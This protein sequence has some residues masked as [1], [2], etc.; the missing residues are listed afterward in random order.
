MGFNFTPINYTKIRG[1]KTEDL[2]LTFTHDLVSADGVYGHSENE[3]DSIDLLMNMDI[4]ATIFAFYFTYGILDNLD[5]GVAV[6][7]INVNMKVNPVAQIN[8]YTFVKNGSANHHFGA[9]GDGANP[10]NLTKVLEGIDDDATGIGDIAFRLK[11]QFL[12]KSAI[13]LA[14]IFEYRLSNGEKD[15]FLGSGDDRMRIA[16]IASK[17]IGD[18]AP[19]IN[20]SYELKNSDTQRDRFGLFIGYDQKI[21]ET[22]TLAIDFLGEFEIG[23]QIKELTFPKERVATGN[24][25]FEIRHSL[26]NL[27]ND[28]TDHLI[29]GAIGFKFN[30]RKNLLIIT[31]VFFPLNEGGLRADFIPTIGA[32]FSF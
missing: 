8:S 6:P 19:H 28:D 10:D 4:N 22:I 30:P 12:D 32:E 29:N 15:D 7:F 2:R 13:D 26:T 31:N 9:E 11:Y 3:F 1:I 5:F 24:D 21:T 23:D 17:I 16:L 25:G 20:L 14:T 27:P 18:I